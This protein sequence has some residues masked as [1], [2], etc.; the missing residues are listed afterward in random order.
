MSGRSRIADLPVLVI[1]VL[2]LSTAADILPNDS[3][4]GVGDVQ[5]N[6]ARLLVLIGLGAFVATPGL[7]LPN[8]LGGYLLL[9]LPLG[10]MAS[11]YIARVRGV[12]AAVALAGGLGFLALVF[13][14]SRAAVLMSLVAITVGVLV[15]DLRYRRLLILVVVAAAA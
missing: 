12:W 13:T 7:R 5:L 15:S 1:G 4:V 11:A 9:L 6:L 14:F 2:L 3:I 10:A 8:V